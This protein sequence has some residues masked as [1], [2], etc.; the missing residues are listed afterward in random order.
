MAEMFAK[1][2]HT[3]VPDC[4]LGVVRDGGDFHVNLYRYFVNYMPGICLWNNGGFCT[5]G[6][7]LKFYQI[8]SFS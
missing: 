2:L 8:V 3:K 5:M 6:F 4:T 1:Q 7:V